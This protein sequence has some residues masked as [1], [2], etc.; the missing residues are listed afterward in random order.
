MAALK[1]VARPYAKA[2]FEVARDQDLVLEWANMLSALAAVTKDVKFKVALGDPVYSTMEKVNVLVQVCEEVMIEQ[3][4][5][6]LLNLAENKRLTLLP[7]IF[8][9]FQQFKLN[10]EKSVDVELTSAFELSA[11]Q[12][13]TLADSLAKR[14]DST[15]NVTNETDTSLIGGVVI[16]IG[17]LVIDGSVRGKL[18]KLV[19]SVNS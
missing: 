14:L 15:I 5:A 6:F 3:G 18:A 7:V 13:Q 2:A 4:K 17:D 16:R 12:I 10:F 11:K 1:T 9:L 19:E 8:T